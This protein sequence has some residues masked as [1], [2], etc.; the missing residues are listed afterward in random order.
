MSFR[1]Q[2]SLF[3]LVFSHSVLSAPIAKFEQIWVD[4]GLPSRSVWATVQDTNG[5]VWLATSKGLAKFDGYS[6]VT[7]NNKING[8]KLSS[9]WIRTLLGDK[10]GNIWIGTENNGLIQYRTKSNSFKSYPVATQE[11]TSVRSLA[12]DNQENLWIGTS[13]GLAK[14]DFAKD[15]IDFYFDR[16]EF[17]SWPNSLVRKLLYTSDNQLYAGTSKGLYKLNLNSL[18]SSGPLPTFST[19]TIYSLYQSSNQDLFV[20][21]KNGLFTYN[22]SG[23]KIIKPLA[24]TI[25]HAITVDGQNNL[26]VGTFRK[27]LYKIAPDG[28]FRN[29]HYEKG[30]PH[31]FSGHDVLSLL[32]DKSNTLWAGTFDAGINKLDLLSLQFE[33]YDDSKSSLPCLKDS[34]IYSIVE[35]SDEVWL[36]TG[37][38]LFSVNLDHQQCRIIDNYQSE[39]LGN[40][41]LA[42]AEYDQNTLLVGTLRNI[43]LFK[44][45]GKTAEPLSME[46]IAN[47]F[48]KDGNSGYYISTKSGAYYFSRGNAQIEKLS[49]RDNS[50]QNTEISKIQKDSIGRLWMASERGLLVRKP[51]LETTRAKLSHDVSGEIGIIF[52]DRSSRLWVGIE[53][54][55]LLVFDVSS[56]NVRLLHSFKEIKSLHGFTSIEESNGSY[57]WISSSN[58]LERINASNWSVDHFDSR[59]GLQSNLFTRGASF[60]N[61]KGV[62]YFGGR[63]G[64]TRF[65]SNT[66][67]KNSHPP[68]TKISKLFIDGSEV[69]DR[70]I[71]NISYENGQVSELLL[72]YYENNFGFEFSALHFA[73]PSKNKYTYIMEGW[74]N[75]WINVDSNNRRVNYDNL[76]P[77]EY[78]FK[79][80]SSNNHL[81]WSNL[82]EKVSITIS[83]PPWNTWWAYILYLALLSIIFYSH[84]KYRTKKLEERA[85]MLESSVIE[86]TKEL[87]FEKDKVERILSKKNEEFANVSHEFR[88]PLTLVIG[89]LQK[90]LIDEANQDRK[91]SLSM[92]K[93]N[94]FRLL[95]MV[96]QLLHLEK[97]RVQQIVKKVPIRVQPIAKLIAE[98]FAE[99][100]KAN[101][102]TMTIGRID[103]IWLQFTPDALEKILLNLL[104]NSVK[105]SQPGDTIN[106]SI[107]KDS[108]NSLKIVVEDSGIGI[109]KNKQAEIFERFSRVLDNHSEQITGAGIGL[110]L[111]KELVES[112][113]GRI[114][115]KSALGEGC[116]FTVTLPAIPVPRSTQNTDSSVEEVIKELNNE[117][118]DMEIESLVEQSRKPDIDSQIQGSDLS[119]SLP[120]L[121]IVEDNHD[122]R[123][124]I[125]STLS[126]RFNILTAPN[127]KEG[128]ALAREHIPDLVVSDVMMPQMDGFTLCH[129]LKSGELT[130]H[131]PLIL[132]TARSDRDSRLRGWKEQADEY[133]TKPF[134]AEEL[135]LRV[136]NLLDI[137]ELLKQ[138]FYSSIQTQPE[139]LNQTTADLTKEEDENSQWE[140]HQKLFLKRFIEQIENNIDNPQLKVADIASSL[141]MTERQLYRK[142]KGVINVTP[143]EYLKN[144]RLDKA[145]NLLKNGEPVGNVA[146]DVGFTSH[147]YFSR[148]FKAKFGCSPREF[149]DH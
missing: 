27:G 7:F 62:M 100:A 37:N 64:L 57:I 54:E 112:H 52:L 99:L 85:E 108:E 79:V 53:N 89:P 144:H 141:T 34:V 61:Q 21:T 67:K 92:V 128:L 119:D 82:P 83:P 130:S 72:N 43:E 81:L 118:L 10:Q 115:L 63:K 123:S 35:S 86:R 143:S 12:F 47:D 95:R 66:I 44:K 31:S 78:Q 106:F 102:I 49:T 121:L 60:S 104:S 137:R 23:K 76:P 135:N 24:N 149:G 69:L 113:N 98:S 65:N 114:T 94:A 3:F 129:E 45:E 140:E 134:D 15:N 133:L 17:R 88:T 25:V 14:L 109:P 26:W 91:N 142:L 4:S 6:F 74:N 56:K 110:S 40:S 116:C 30:N 77:G 36:G 131:I 145:L 2:V 117:I 29:F 147:S 55:T 46:L 71:K 18:S 124:Y 16:S 101:N 59:D 41:I 33:F 1:F 111:V 127:G 73:S 11:T 125:T 120:T 19:N 136:N 51:G 9:L 39:T 148:C 93:R 75:G 32:V 70:N 122:M 22:I 58:G 96:D 84:T 5:F 105:Y 13:K 107:L 90:L 20:G 97:F 103:D 138:R 80:K 146:F 50:L 126:G 139:Q 28:S 48:L 8:K 87:A 68:K 132:L 42:L 38:G